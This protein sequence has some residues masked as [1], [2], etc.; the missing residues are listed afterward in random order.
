MR[1]N[2]SFTSHGNV[3]LTYKEVVMWVAGETIQTLE[4]DYYDLESAT[5]FF[6]IIS[7][8]KVIA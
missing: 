3:E 5:R 4:V 6:V 7:D 1:D 2:G 8:N